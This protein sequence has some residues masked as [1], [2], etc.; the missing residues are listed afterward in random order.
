ML[1]SVCGEGQPVRPAGVHRH[2]LAVGDLAG[3]H[4]EG[5]RVEH[6]ALN[7]AAKR[8]CAESRVV[9]LAREQTLGVVG[10][11]ECEMVID[12]AALDL[13]ELEIDDA[14]DLLGA[15]GAEDDHLVDAVV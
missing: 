6:E 7:G 13:G 10:D 1:S 9:A 8:A 11:A 12:E 14:E 15:E 4:L 5:E 2:G 3:E